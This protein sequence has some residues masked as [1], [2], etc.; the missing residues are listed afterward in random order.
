MDVIR[1]CDQVGRWNQQRKFQDASA[2]HIINQSA[3]CKA[4]VKIRDHGHNSVKVGLLYNGQTLIRRVF[5]T[6]HNQIH[7]VLCELLSA[8]AIHF[9]KSL[10]LSVGVE[11][12]ELTCDDLRLAPIL[13]AVVTVR[14]LYAGT[15]VTCWTTAPSHQK[16]RS[17]SALLAAVCLLL[18]TLTIAARCYAS[19]NATHPLA[20]LSFQPR[21]LSSITTTINSKEN[22]FQ[23]HSSKI[24]LSRYFRLPYKDTQS[25]TRVILRDSKNLLSSRNFKINSLT[26]FLNAENRKKRE[27][28]NN[29]EK[30]LK[31]YQRYDDKSITD[32]NSALYNVERVHPNSDYSNIKNHSDI[33]TSVNASVGAWNSSVNAPQVSGQSLKPS[34]NEEDR[35][36]GG[37]DIERP[38]PPAL[39]HSNNS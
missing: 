19:K 23:T 9:P 1:G 34:D 17:S 20:Q 15:L 12:F 29:Q 14:A 28:Q 32:Q 10:H 31:N 27:L 22:K 24:V 5:F 33:V 2:I 38:M 25:D 16:R 37:T 30:V 26:N 7:L 21:I 4:T 35:V 39:D 18:A 3:L 8:S 6:V 36:S 13:V 11:N